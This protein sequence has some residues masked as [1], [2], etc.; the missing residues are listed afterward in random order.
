M[1]QRFAGLLPVAGRGGDADSA[2]A[3]GRAFGTGTGEDAATGRSRPN[4]RLC[5]KL[6]AAR[7]CQ[8]NPDQ[9]DL[10]PGFYSNA[11][12]SGLTSRINST[13]V[14]L[15]RAIASAVVGRYRATRGRK[16]KTRMER[17]IVSRKQRI[18][19]RNQSQKS[20]VAQANDD[21]VNPTAVVTVT[22]HQPRM[23]AS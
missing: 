22:P 1:R 6:A 12:Q 7:L 11:G 19:L 13:V 2:T 21:E 10:E 15:Q 5:R 9:S 14:L 23:S 4:H 17:P 18:F 3:P 16:S 20:P 8:R